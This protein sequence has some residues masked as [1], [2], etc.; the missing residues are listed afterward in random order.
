M[1]NIVVT[2]GTKDSME[3]FILGLFILAMILLGI[4]T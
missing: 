2:K 1:K 3:M 4:I